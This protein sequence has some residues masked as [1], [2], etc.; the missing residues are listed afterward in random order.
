M[1]V[2]VAIVL[3]LLLEIYVHIVLYAGF[4]RLIQE[5]RKVKYESLKMFWAAQRSNAVSFWDAG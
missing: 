3:F 2:A 5:R 1:L 4:G